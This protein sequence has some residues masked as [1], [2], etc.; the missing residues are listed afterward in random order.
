MLVIFVLAAIYSSSGYDPLVRPSIGHPFEE[1]KTPWKNN[2][3]GM[4]GPVRLV[5]K[6]ADKPAEADLLWE[7]NTVDSSW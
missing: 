6:P 1:K 3:S 4:A 2:K 5:L 7:K